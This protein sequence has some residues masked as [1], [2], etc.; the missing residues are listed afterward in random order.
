MDSRQRKRVHWRFT[1]EEYRALDT[2]D[3]RA[4]SPAPTKSNETTSDEPTGRNASTTVDVLSANVPPTPRIPYVS[5]PPDSPVGESVP[6]PSSPPVA[7]GIIIHPVLAAGSESCLCLDVSSHLRRNPQLL[8]LGS[9]LNAPASNPALSSLQIHAETEQYIFD[10]GVEPKAG[11]PQL[12][13]SS[14]GLPYVTIGRV[15]ADLNG[16]FRQ[17]WKEDISDEVQWYFERRVMTVN[18]GDGEHTEQ[19]TEQRDWS[20]E[21][22]RQMN[23]QEER[24]KGI[25]KVDLLLGHTKFMGLSAR[26]VDRWIMHLSVPERYA[27]SPGTP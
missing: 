4:T 21:I 26:E 24:A 12:Y 19:H 20:A 2:V 18:G 16:Y 15:L 27:R 10:I 11:D 13:P 9:L 14:T 25:R 22:Q 1:A 5:L 8:D 7:P 3:S 17:E 23:I 6:L